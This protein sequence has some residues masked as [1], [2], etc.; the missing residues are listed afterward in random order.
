[1][2]HYIELSGKRGKGHRTIVDEETYNK[3]NHLSWFLG[4]TGYA[5]RRSDKL[6]DGT[7]VT[8]RLHRLVI[9]A[10]EG[11]VVDHLNGDKL[12]NRK[13]NLR[14][15]TQT[16]NARNRKDTT[17][18]CFDKTRNK[19]IVRYRNKFF[20]R[21]KTEE[22]ASRAYQLAKSGVEYKTRRRMRYMLP[23]G[24][25]YHKYNK[26]HYIVRPQL[27]GKR[28]FLGYF[29]TAEEAKDVYDNFRQKEK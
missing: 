22:E 6:D 4:D 27:N 20:G 7:K 13:S 14:V 18:I 16:D 11:M 19:W 28:Y 21:Y 5:M 23:K 24:V 17:G 29:A 15:C 3:Y 9:N 10:P 12:D 1:M 2:T 26:K 25:F 8:Q